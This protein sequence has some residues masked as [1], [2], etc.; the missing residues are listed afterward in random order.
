MKLSRLAAL[1][2]DG[3]VRIGGDWT[4]HAAQGQT[5]TTR[6][7]DD[8]FRTLSKTQ[9]RRLLE[10]RAFHYNISRTNAQALRLSMISWE[11]SRV[12]ILVLPQPVLELSHHQGVLPSPLLQYAFHWKRPQLFERD[13][14]A[15][16]GCIRIGRSIVQVC[17]RLF[18]KNSF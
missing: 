4:V 15:S 8:G 16:I 6:M 12:F 9:Q 14:Q 13:L 11:S 7:K 18:H 5:I 17:G 3:V 2:E 1:F 10:V